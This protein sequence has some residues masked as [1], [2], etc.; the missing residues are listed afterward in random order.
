MY[1]LLST[2]ST[3][4]TSPSS[5]QVVRLSSGRA[6]LLLLLPGP[7]VAALDEFCY[8]HGGPLS[9]GDV[10]DLPGGRCAVV[11]PWH[12]YRIDVRSGEC[13]YIG[14]DPATGTQTWR[15]KGVKQRPHAV[16]VES[17][18]S[19]WVEDSG[20]AGGEGSAGGGECAERAVAAPRR[21][22]S[23]GYAF[24]NPG[25]PRLDAEVPMRSGGVLLHS[26]FVGGG[27]AGGGVGQGGGMGAGVGAEDAGRAGA[28]MELDER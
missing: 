28:A 25:P 7:S 16:R 17:D 10:E 20:A 14:I 8:H 3:L 22:E 4:S 6:I 24:M 12:R 27:R 5:R 1:E 13:L 11:C 9:G 18:G 23:D 21:L 26:S 2:L 15:S 19:V